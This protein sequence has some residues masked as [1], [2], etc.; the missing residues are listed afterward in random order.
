MEHSEILLQK[1]IEARRLSRD[2]SFQHWLQYEVFTWKWWLLILMTIVPYIIVWKIIDRKRILEIAVYGL[3]INIF[4]TILDM[5]GSQFVQWDYTMRI[6]PIAA[7]PFPYDFTILPML[8]ML[9]Y[10]R[11]SKW[12]DYI[13]AIT[14]VS[15][16]FTLVAEPLLVT[17][18]MYRL[19]N[20]KYIYSFPI[21]IALAIFS[22]WLVEQFIA[23]QNTI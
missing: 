6:I 12:K 4:S 22:R 11:Y 16:I 23:E 3:H 7:A 20:W 18:H 5:L 10:Q 21:Y 19:F 8:F 13:I 17:L 9:I 1:L 15:A 2:L 14:I